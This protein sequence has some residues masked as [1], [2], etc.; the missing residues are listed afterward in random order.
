MAV[1][2]IILPAG[3][4]STQIVT[5]DGVRVSLRVWW[6]ARVQRWLLDVA[7]GAGEPIASGLALVTGRSLLSRFGL[8]DDLPPGVLTALDTA[9]TGLEAGRDDLGTRVRL[10]Y[11]DTDELVA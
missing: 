4:A 6:N 1:F 11:Y 7:T 5:L 2:E 10:Y 3:P 8:R 9:N